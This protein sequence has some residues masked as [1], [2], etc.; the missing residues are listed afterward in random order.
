MESMVP[1][2]AVPQLHQAAV[3]CSISD[4]GLSPTDVHLISLHLQ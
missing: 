4:W 3:S 2:G 1:I